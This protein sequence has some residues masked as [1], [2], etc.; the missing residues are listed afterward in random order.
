MG[1]SIT[2]SYGEFTMEH[3]T[4]DETYAAM[5]S[6]TYATAHKFLMSQSISFIDSGVLDETDADA[7]AA[8]LIATTKLLE[9]VDPEE[10]TVEGEE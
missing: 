9:T 1:Y 3:A 8:E 5:K 7:E 2:Y 6:G 4:D 10:E